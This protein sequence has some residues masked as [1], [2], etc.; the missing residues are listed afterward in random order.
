MSQINSTY[1]RHSTYSSYS[2]D[3]ISTDDTLRKSTELTSKHLKPLKH[4]R[5]LKN[6]VHDISQTDTRINDIFSSKSLKRNV[7]APS[8]STSADN[9]TQNS[10]TAS[11]FSTVIS[12]TDTTV[13][14]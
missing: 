2:T 9:S 5:P 11:E 12:K 1:S 13:S 6:Q 3:N 10:A 14:S 4:S 7:S 8:F